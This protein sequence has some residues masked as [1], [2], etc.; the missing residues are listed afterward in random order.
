MEGEGNQQGFGMNIYDLR[1]GE[2]LS[3][4]PLAHKMPSISSNA[5]CANNPIMLIEPDG[6]PTIIPWL[7][8]VGVGAAGDM[9]A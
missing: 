1:I 7:L 8:K 3:N 9:M 2:F 4:D 5:F 6:R